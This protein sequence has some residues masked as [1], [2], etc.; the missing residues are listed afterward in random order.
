MW[1]VLPH[2]KLEGFWSKL[3]E[4]GEF[5]LDML[6]KEMV[7]M[8]SKPEMQKDRNVFNTCFRK[9]GGRSTEVDYIM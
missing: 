3:D 4:E 8:E 6:V 7:D 9:S 5:C 2:H 1:S